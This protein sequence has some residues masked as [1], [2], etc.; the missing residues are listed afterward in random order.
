MPPVDRFLSDIGAGALSTAVTLPQGPP[1]ADGPAAQLYK[2]IDDEVTA[3]NDRTLALIKD[4]WDDFAG[5]LRQG[6]EL[7][8]KLDE[9]D[10]ELKALELAVDGPDAFLPPL[11]A[12]LEEQQSLA[13]SHLVTTASVSLLTALVAFHTTTSALASATTSGALP[14][15]IE[16]LARVTSAVEDGADEWIEQTDA[17][18]ALVRWAGEEESRLEAALQG[19]LEGCFEL[20]PAPSSSSGGGSASL[21]LR[22]RIAAAPSGPEIPV[23]ELLQGLEDLAGITGR[24]TQTEGFLARLAKQVLRHFVAP[25]LEA[26]GRVALDEAAAE[27]RGEGKKPKLAFSFRDEGAAHVVTLAQA[28]DD[29]PADTIAALSDFL[30]FFTKHSSLFP[31]PGTAAKPSK[32][33][34]TLTA[35]LTPSLQSHL[36]SSHLSPSLPASTSALP[37]Y[38][39]LVS[40]AST[41]EASFLPSHGLF[42]FLPSSLSASSREVEEQRVIRT[43][44]ARVPH[45]WARQAGDRAL[46]RV[47]AAVKNWDWGAGEEVEVE[48]RE[49]DEMLGLLLGLGL[50]DDA[51]GGKE[52][53]ELALQTVPRGAKREMTMEE[54][55]APKAPR[56][57]SPPPPPPPPAAPAPAPAE[58]APRA[59]S[60]PPAPPQQTKGTLKRGKLGA[61]R[62]AAPLL[63]PR[64][65]SPPPLF[66]GGDAPAPSPSAPAPEPH[67]LDQSSIISPVLSPR[68]AHTTFE[69]LEEPA[70]SLDG[71]ETTADHAGEGEVGGKHEYRAVVEDERGEEGAEKHEAEAGA[72]KHEAEAGAD[73]GVKAE[74]EDEPRPEPEEEEEVKPRVDIKEESVEP[75]IPPTP[76]PALAPAQRRASHS[77]S[78]GLTFDEPS[79]VRGEDEEDVKPVVDEY[80]VAAH[81]DERAPADSEEPHTGNDAPAPPPPQNDPYPPSSASHDPYAP[82]LQ[83][84]GPIAPSP[85]AQHE[86]YSSLV[87]VP[88]EE[89]YAAEE[90]PY[91]PAGEDELSRGE[92]EEVHDS[93]ALS[94]GARDSYPPSEEAHDPYPPSKEAHDP[95]PPYK[96]AHDPY[97]PQDEHAAYAPQDEHASYAPLEQAH[98]PYAAEIEHHD[99]YAP[100]SAAHDPYAVDAAAHD[101]HDPYAVDV[102]APEAHDP[103]T[104]ESG[105]PYAVASGAHDS[106]D[107]YTE[108]EARADAHD[109]YVP[110]ETA[111]ES[112]D[113]YAAPAGNEHDP[114][115]APAEVE[116]DP[117]APSE[118]ASAPVPAPTAHDP[119]AADPYAAEVAE[120]DWYAQEEGDDWYAQQEQAFT[121]VEQAQDPLGAQKYVQ[122]SYAPQ[123]PAH[124]PYA[125]QGPAHDPYKPYG[126]EPAQ[127]E[128][129]YAPQHDA[130]APIA[131]EPKQLTPAPPAEQTSPVPPP[132]ASPPGA[133]TAPLPPAVP[134]PP[135][136]AAAPPPPQQ[137]QGAAPPPPRAGGAAPPPRSLGRAGGKKRQVYT[138]QYDLGSSTAAP[139]SAAPLAS[140]FQQNTA[141]PPRTTISPP[142]VEQHQNPY[143]PTVP[144]IQPSA[145]SPKPFTPTLS[146]RSSSNSLARS[147]PSR[148]T[149]AQRNDGPVLNH[150]QQR[151]ASPPPRQASPYVPLVAPPVAPQT[152]YLPANDPLFADLLGSGGNKA[153]QSANFFAPDPP[154]PQR[155]PSALSQGSHAAAYGQPQQGYAPP[156]QQYGYAPPQQHYQAQQQQQY[157]G[158]YDVHD[159]VEELRDEY[160]AGYGAPHDQQQPY[161]GGYNPYS[162]EQ[163]AMR[164]RGGGGVVWDSEDED[165]GEERPVLRLRGGADLGEMD[166]DDGNRSADDW[167]LD[168]DL[169]GEDDG[170]GFGDDVEPPSGP[171]SPPPAPKPA[172]LPPRAAKPAPAPLFSP[173]ARASPVATPTRPFS[174]APSA[175]IAS[176]ASSTGSLSR[177]RPP[178]YAFSPSLAPPSLPALSLAG[179]DEEPEEA[180][181]DWGFGDEVDEA[182]PSPQPPSAPSPPAEVEQPAPPIPAE[183]PAPRSPSPQPPSPPAPAPA[184]LE[185]DTLAADEPDAVGDDSWGFGVEDG[186]VE[187]EADDLAESQVVAEQ[188]TD[189]L[190][191]EQAVEQADT[192]RHSPPPPAVADEVLDDEQAPPRQEIEP[193]EDEGWGLDE[194]AD[195]TQLELLPDSVEQALASDAPAEADVEAVLP[196]HEEHDAP[197]VSSPPLVSQRD[198]V[199][200]QDPD[201]VAFPLDT[202]SAPTESEEEHVEP[203]QQD[204]ELEDVSSAAPVDVAQG[205]PDKGRRASIEVD[206]T[207]PSALNLPAE[208]IDDSF[209]TPPPVIERETPHI[210]APLPH[211]DV[212]APAVETP[213]KEADLVGIAAGPV[214][215]AAQFVDGDAATDDWGLGGD[216]EDNAPAE[217]APVDSFL[218]DASEAD[219]QDEQLP[220]SST[221]FEPQPAGIDDDFVDFSTPVQAEEKPA[222][223]QWEPFEDPGN[224]PIVS[225]P[226]NAQKAS[227]HDD[228]DDDVLSPIARAVPLAEIE[229]L[230]SQ[231][232][233]AQE[234]VGAPIDTEQSAVAPP[235]EGSMSS[236]EVIEHADAWGLEEG[237]E[238]GAEVLEASPQEP[239]VHDGVH[240]S[241]VQHELERPTLHD[242][243]AVQHEEARPLID[244]SVVA[245]G[246]LL[247]AQDAHPQQRTF[248]PPLSAVPGGDAGDK[249]GWDWQDDSGAEALHDEEV[250]V[251]EEGPAPVPAESAV[252]HEDERLVVPSDG[253]DAPLPAET[254]HPQERTL[255]PPPSALPGGDAAEDSGWDWQDDAGAEA[256]HDEQV[257]VT[258]EGPMPIPGESA[259]QHEDERL[260]VPSDGLDAP[261]PAE[262]AHP[263]DRTL[264]PPPSA[265]PQDEEHGWSFGQEDDG[266]EL[267]HDEP[268][269]DVEQGAE[270]FDGDSAVQHITE[271]PVVAAIPVEGE[272]VAAELLQPEEHT[273]SPPPSALPSV[274]TDVASH[275]VDD[276]FDDPWDLEPVEPATPVVP[277]SE[278][279]SAAELLDASAADSAASAV[280]P[281][282][283]SSVQH[284]E[285]RPLVDEAPPALPAAQP[286]PQ[287]HTFDPV[288]VPASAPAQTAEASSAREFDPS[289]PAVDP[290]DYEFDDPPADAPAAALLD[291]DEGAA[292]VAPEPAVDESVVQHEQDR[293]VFDAEPEVAASQVQPQE[294]TFS[295][296]TSSVPAEGAPVAAPADPVALVSPTPIEPDEGWGW[297]GDDAEAAPADPPTSLPPILAAVPPPVKQ[298]PLSPTPS[299]GPVLQ[300]P[301]PQHARTMSTDDWS[302]DA[303]E[304][305]VKA[306]APAPA[307][308]P[309]PAAPAAAEADD[310]PE[311]PAPVRREKM[312]VSKQSREIVAIAQEILLEAV[313]VASPSFEHPDFAPAAA[314]LL[315]TFISLL[316]LY[317]ATAAVHNSR[318]LASVPA[319]GMQFAN[320][321]EWIGR[322]VERIWRTATEDKELPVA[323]DQ[324]NEVQL[325]IE[326]TRQLGRDTRQKQIAIQRAALMESLD[327]AGGFL[328]TSDEARFQSCERA[329]QQVTHILQRLALVWKP[330]MTPTALYTSLGGLINEVLLRVLDEIEEQ[331]DISEEESIRLN[332]LCKMLHELESLFD[333][334]ETSIGRESPSWYKFVFL[335]ELLEASMADILF[336]FDHGHLVDFTPQEI[337]RLVRALFADSPLRNRNIEKILRGHPTAPPDEED[338]AGAE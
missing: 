54:A 71:I 185:P 172:P 127:H 49:E 170:W 58:P 298:S 138:P 232:P 313:K 46:A 87:D 165:D 284:I 176:V 320:D 277:A 33:A 74:E 141:P 43:W 76:S 79:P 177:S 330:V 179:A 306:D 242:D 213:V 275:P 38:L 24:Q 281:S 136:S 230:F 250:A 254:A 85:P 278:A 178:S 249:H 167:G 160:T 151:F 98:N 309:V 221:L 126:D 64:S 45:H 225:P 140:P 273:F 137:Q 41:F 163:P 28:G 5:Q 202:T 288:D 39:A 120:E 112:H 272:L 256:L 316:S 148:P 276:T 84:L 321:A 326:S 191:Y 159:A 150:I 240:D 145:P 90:D 123:E 40:A 65:P 268:A 283:E 168:D 32:H 222:P 233:L 215:D 8:A 263:Q 295:L 155:S 186:G 121:P 267:L 301:A 303:E 173:P 51:E 262:T 21:T 285:D 62:I 166:D 7:I 100:H 243:S 135:R 266:A 287:Q 61:A 147:L 324:A 128:D 207:E 97:A 83:P 50:A 210:P 338:W 310:P 95:Y 302:W 125:P 44:A 274:D 237:E 305:D 118:Q 190:E 199:E 299:T 6:D 223:Q 105:D 231:E 72:E 252:Q 180:A 308:A 317:R 314:P 25:F 130:Y 55:L 318:L 158:G 319:I 68:G 16:A 201:L 11:V 205:Q 108:L 247:P 323:Q 37:A 104:V 161:G 156:Q 258:E 142:P 77:P 66:Q 214:D 264:S 146:T 96:E 22:E 30:A 92:E 192:V 198:S 175:S 162:Y 236:P 197:A 257:A 42:A 248:S 144:P 114:Y 322:E 255:S 89:P 218:G 239:P 169:G 181:D 216:D 110:V 73:A 19:A 224:Q 335:S 311:A 12:H 203:A 209:P 174:H 133:S 304:K 189:F 279:A 269:L 57:V 331:T 132:A 117:Y 337:V 260:V 184:P 152:S 93:Y 91:A 253:L 238:G 211:H 246:G 229:Q 332:K 329:L 27:E 251:T 227:H 200:L 334:S 78:L 18:K 164:M 101:A 82:P 217:L 81:V 187:S 312:M 67:A 291:A 328:R 220:M 282:T 119:F 20:V 149:S 327:E 206:Q 34:A 292:D 333:G 204:D 234:A 70:L 154:A 13:A 131:H 241:V 235:R 296:P 4:N 134:P 47:R 259:G 102:E 139:P 226:L 15:A 113:P 107:P 75:E 122:E 56:A 183:A 196:T 171:P 23:Q 94:A 31:A 48:V 153:S 111:E 86:A 195:E 261:L 1:G 99:P 300:A 9:E 115:A 116:H 36:I 60:P 52:P 2:R 219:A 143:T 265:V 17:W 80:A 10:K 297:D 157:G 59:G 245:P 280:P 106:H 124:D 325:A 188:P 289:E 29:A 315:Q 88:A 182:P 109:P 63:A 35:H 270:P 286:Q 26:N 69:L 244:D 103:Y 228:E 307:P 290:L 271:R 14:S 293:P 129:P 53:G 336:L 294:H 194:T 193:F 208:D 212:P 3:T